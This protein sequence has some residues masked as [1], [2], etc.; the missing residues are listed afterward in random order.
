MRKLALV[1]MMVATSR[2]AIGMRQGWRA[3]WRNSAPT[4]QRSFRMR[5]V[6]STTALLGSSAAP[7][8]DI[9]KAL[10]AEH[11][12]M[13]LA[14]QKLVKKAHLQQDPQQEEKEAAACCGLWSMLMRICGSSHFST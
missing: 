7:A 4:E 13:Y 1:C 3:P 2:Q 5:R 10:Q 11:P 12:S 8:D 6:N 14:K 9:D